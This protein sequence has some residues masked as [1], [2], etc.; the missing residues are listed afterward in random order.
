MD[1]RH[2]GRKHQSELTQ[3]VRAIGRQGRAAV[4]RLYELE[5]Q[6]AL[7]LSEKHRLAVISSVTSGAKTLL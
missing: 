4:R 6:L 7:C 5:Y 3:H 1:A 2:Q